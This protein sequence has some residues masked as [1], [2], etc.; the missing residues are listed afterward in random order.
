MADF[1]ETLGVSKNATA[2]EIKKAYRKIALKYHPDRNPGNEEAA[3]KFKEASMAYETL[4]NQEKRSR[5]DQFGH[6]AYTRQGGAGGAGG[7]GFDPRDI[8]SQF[9]GGGAGGGGFS[10]DD[11]FGGG[12][13]R[14]DPNAPRR[15]DDLRFDLE[16]DFVDAMFGAERS[17]NVNR[18]ESCSACSGSGCEVGSGKKSCP[19][20]GGTGFRTVSQGFFQM[21]QECRNCGG[22]GQVIEKPCKKCRGA[23]QVSVTTPLQI[24][25]PAGV[26]T[27]S[28]LRVPGKGSAGFNGGPAG[29]L[30][31]VFHVRPSKIFERD[32]NDLYCEVPL[33]FSVAANGGVVDVPT[34]SGK[35]SIRVPAGTQN[36]DVLRVRGKGAPSLR[37]G[38]RGD[39][40]IRFLIET[41]VK[42]S[43]E[44]QKMLDDF[45]ASL[46]ESNLPLKK[47][48]VE[49]AGN[50]FK[51]E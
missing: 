44:Q 17:I 12:S 20:C 10:F 24:R 23:G 18:A 31:I 43:K 30:Y 15:G 4:S 16:I 11:L 1:Y 41:P 35:M 7:A 40:H 22:T 25:I 39:L 27:G 45:T 14:S 13:R 2:D 21:R 29:N 34:L 3:E 33:L 51:G 47:K 38:G 49:R 46:Q 36:G 42:L 26:D 6:E 32:G 48:F 28:Q 19:H 5:Y 8:F 9:F 37:G 50:F